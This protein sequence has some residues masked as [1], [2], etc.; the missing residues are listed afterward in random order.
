MWFNFLASFSMLSN[1]T[2]RVKNFKWQSLDTA[3]RKLNAKEGGGDEVRRGGGGRG[4]GG[5]GRWGEEE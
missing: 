4:E 3:G 1:V 5:G 2:T